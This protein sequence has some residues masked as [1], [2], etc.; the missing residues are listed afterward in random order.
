MSATE[1]KSKKNPLKLAVTKGFLLAL[2]LTFFLVFLLAILLHFTELTEN[3]LETLSLFIL[4]LSIVGGGMQAA[5][6]AESRFLLQGLG[7]GLLYMA[8]IVIASYFSG[9]TIVG[10]S[11]FKKI[12]YCAG[13]GVIG[14]LIGAI[15]R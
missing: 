15:T 4:I 11:F 10:I 3:F 7:V 6:R 1:L 5:K 2:F 8:V 13:S 9:Y 12:L 14:G